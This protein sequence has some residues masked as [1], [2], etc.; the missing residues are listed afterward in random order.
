MSEIEMNTESC[1]NIVYFRD[2]GCVR[3]LR[4]LFVYATEQRRAM[5]VILAIFDLHASCTKLLAWHVGLS[6][7]EV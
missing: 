5:Y 1:F 7:R 2:R 3:T 4:P 6:L